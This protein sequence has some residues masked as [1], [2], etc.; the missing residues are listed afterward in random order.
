MDTGL[1]KLCIF[2]G[3]GDSCRRKFSRQDLWS[4]RRLDKEGSEKQTDYY[5]LRNRILL[6]SKNQG[7]G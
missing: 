2:P 6:K 4:Q 3:G 5:K 7:F 1:Q